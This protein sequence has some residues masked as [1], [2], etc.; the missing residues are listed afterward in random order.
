MEKGSAQYASELAVEGAPSAGALR[1]FLQDTFEDA[2]DAVAKLKPAPAAA[3]AGTGESRRQPSPDATI[4]PAPSPN[5][6]SRRAES[7]ALRNALDALEAA[8]SNPSDDGFGEKVRTFVTG[9]RDVRIA[10]TNQLRDQLR[11]QVPDPVQQEAISLYRDFKNRPGELEQFSTGNAPA[12]ATMNPPDRAAAEERIAKLAKPIAFALNP[13]PEMLAADQRLTDYFTAHLAEG[14]KI[15]FLDSTIGNEEY[16]T[17]LFQPRDQEE[18]QSRMGQL[19]RGKLGPRKFRFA[20]ERQFPTILDAVA[21]GAK[22]RSMNAF[23]ALGVYGEKYATTAAFHILLQALRQTA[24]G[25]WGTFS[26]QRKGKIPSDWVELAPESHIF[27]NEVPFMDAGGEPSVA[28]QSLFV[29]PELEEFLRPILDPNFMNRLPAFQKGRM[30]QAYIKT[31]ELGLSI[32]HLRALGI[33]ALGNENVDG[34][35]K[36]MRA[37]L[38]SSTFLAAERSWVRAGLVTPILDRTVEIYRAINPSSLPTTAEQ[39]RS[40]PGLKQIDALASAISHLTFGIVQ[41]KMKVTDASL[42]HAGWMAKHPEATPEESFEAQRQIA[43]QVNATYGGLHWENLGVHRMALELSKALM[44]APDWTYSNLLNL[45]YAGQG[46]PAGRAARLFWLRSILFG[47]A[48]TAGLSLLLS[49]KMPKDPTEVCLGKDKQGND[50][51]DN[52][53]FVGAPGDLS[54]LV[55]NVARYGAVVGLARS[56]AAKF[57]PFAKAGIHL[58]TNQDAKG[59][60]IIPKTTNENLLGQQTQRHE[61]GTLEKTGLGAEEAAR[62]VMPVPFSVSTV[63]RMLTDK[64]QDYTMGEYTTAVLTG[65]QPHPATPPPK[66]HPASGG[67]T[68]IYGSNAFNAPLGK[69]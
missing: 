25:K 49:K 41:R 17:H 47:V 26:Q 37:D 48:L 7:G 18:K 45:K 60:P 19:F 68:G 11:K 3:P 53:F 30:Y 44:L 50:L 58:A 64:K 28:H 31:I 8:V 55:H 43:K 69:W 5:P 36:T 59:R 40:I 56:I 35:I 33:T 23:D 57:G 67:R 32:F 6:R 10:E 9:E 34:L 29:P 20:K 13:T 63:A 16:I 39:I 15:G 12:F 21:A 51:Y 1:D 24:A 22:V 2:R 61:P 52:I 38:E 27:R 65:K 46:G 66:G 42:Q 54:M 62:S 14:R 4:P